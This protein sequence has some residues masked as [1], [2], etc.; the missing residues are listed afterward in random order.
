MGNYGQPIEE[1]SAEVKKGRFGKKNTVRLTLY[2]GQI[3]G[4]GFWLNGDGLGQI[5]LSFDIP[6]AQVRQVK[7]I[8]I[9]GE[10]CLQIEYTKDK[11]YSGNKQSVVFMGIQDCGHWIDLINS[12]KDR[13]QNKERL[14]RDEA[15]K[16]RLE[17]EEQKT[18]RAKA[19]EAAE[20]YF[21]GCMN[22]HMYAMDYATYECHQGDCQLTAIFVG[23]QDGAL[24]FINVDGMCLRTSHAVLPLENVQ[25]FG[26]AS[27]IQREGR[28]SSENFAGSLLGEFYAQSA[29]MWDNILVG[30]LGLKQGDVYSNDDAVSA[31]ESDYEL[32]TDVTSI[33]THN[34]V[35]NFYSDTYGKNID[36]ELPS[37]FYAF[38]QEQ[39]EE[40]NFEALFVEEEPVEPVATE[41]VQV[42][43]DYTFQ[44]Q[45][46]DVQASVQVDFSAETSIQD[47]EVE[48]VTVEK[49]IPVSVPIP[50]T[51]S[52]PVPESVS[53]PISVEE[54]IGISIPIVET[55]EESTP[56]MNYEPIKPLVDSIANETA[57][58]KEENLMSEYG[59]KISVE[60]FKEKIEKLKILRD[61]GLL[62]ETEFNAEKAKL[63]S[64]I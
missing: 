29:E 15:E 59:E 26:M 16:R 46:S 54:P 50:E 52:I 19:Q 11:T 18:L 63:L 25:Y 60:E 53:I 43:E 17:E 9:D 22:Y 47:R 44:P 37:E 36:I 24:H 34:V 12:T 55:V 57:E 31:G 28:L 58:G 14:Q 7:E 62:S 32:P 33:D 40:K 64:L 13:F 10:F 48:G 61:S 30:K 27:V 20:E 2:E 51:V 4:E 21:N 1:F 3:V 39:Y 8:E 56:E 42:E 6:V 35:L 41:T 49:T 38:F 5:M 23:E 45:V